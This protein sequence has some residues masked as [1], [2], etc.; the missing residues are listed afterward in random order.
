MIKFTSCLKKIF[1]ICLLVFPVLVSLGLSTHVF[2]DAFISEH[3]GYNEYFGTPW[4]DNQIVTLIMFVLAFVLLSIYIYI[5]ERKCKC[6]EKTIIKWIVI[7]LAVALVLRIGIFLV[8]Y[9][10]LTVY[11]DAK[12]VWNIMQGDRS[13]EFYRKMMQNGWNNFT[14]VMYILQRLFDPEL[15]ALIA[16]AFVA[17]AIIA[18][19]VF[20]TAYRIFKRMDIAVVAGMFHAIDPTMIL[21][22]FYLSPDVYSLLCLVIGTYFLTFVFEDGNKK[23]LAALAA[24]CFAGV[25]NSFKS[26]SLI[27]VVALVIAVVFRCIRERYTKRQVVSWLITLLLIIVPALGINKVALFCSTKVMH[28]PVQ[29]LNTMHF[30]TVGLNFEGE[31]Q[32]GHGFAGYYQKYR[33]DGVDPKV[34]KEMAIKWLKNGWAESDRSVSEWMWK[35]IQWAWRDSVRTYRSCAKGSINEDTI[36]TPAAEF[37]IGYWERNATSQT[38]LMYMFI[39]GLTAVGI[40][41][42]LKKYRD[43]DTLFVTN[44]YIFG[45]ALLLL[46]IECQSR[47]KTNIMPYMDIMAALGWCEIINGISKIKDRNRRTL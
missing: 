12:H 44:L 21:R 8:F 6:D 34:A 7:I 3:N 35:K 30:I 41:A 2:V 22:N 40:V 38:Q 29:D 11:G 25:G 1:Y 36:D 10:D 23:Y 37:M 32:I 28:V 18:V 14:V 42:L 43:N 4:F 15:P 45:F 16:T 13:K 39:V 33:D 24:G 9:R 31:G 5:Y 17:D 47:Y 19:F 27:L 26:I 20:L 46:V